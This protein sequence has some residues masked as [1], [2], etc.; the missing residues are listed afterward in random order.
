MDK[1]ELQSV[2]FP[3]F[4]DSQLEALGKCSLTKLRRFHAGDTVFDV[5]DRLCRMFI[6]KSGEIEIVDESGDSPKTVTVHHPGEFTGEVAQITGS[7]SLVK[8]VARSECEA[9][10]RA[11]EALKQLSNQHPE[12]GEVILR[13][14]IARR[15]LL[16]ESGNFTGPRVIGSRYSQDTFRVR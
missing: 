10:E 7:P 12:M 9:V 13:A 11:Q 15:Q 16:H 14:F 2:A 5:G 6:V 8:A 1:H 3:K 4:N